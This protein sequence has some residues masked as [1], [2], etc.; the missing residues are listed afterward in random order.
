MKTLNYIFFSVIVIIDHQSDHNV[1]IVSYCTR[2]IKSDI[3]VS[4][5]N[6]ENIQANI[7]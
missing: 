7:N 2:K 3:T 1:R 6:K 4:T 5:E